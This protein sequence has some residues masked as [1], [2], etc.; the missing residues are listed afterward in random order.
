MHASTV[1]GLG[2]T[3]A[4]GEYGSNHGKR[5]AERYRCTRVGCEVR[6]PT[7]PVRLNRAE[8]LRRFHAF[9]VDGTGTQVRVGKGE[10]ASDVVGRN[11]LAA[12]SLHKH[13]RIWFRQNNLVVARIERGQRVTYER[14]LRLEKEKTVIREQLKKARAERQAKKEM[15][16][17][18]EEATAVAT[19]AAASAA[20]EAAGKDNSI[21]IGLERSPKEADVDQLKVDDPEQVGL[22]PADSADGLKGPGNKTASL[23]QPDEEITVAA[24]PEKA[25]QSSTEKVR[26]GDQTTRQPLPQFKH[27]RRRSVGALARPAVQSA[28][29][30]RRSSVQEMPLYWDLDGE[31]ADERKPLTYEPKLPS[32]HERYLKMFENH[33][34]L[35]SPNKQEGKLPHVSRQQQQL[36]T[37]PRNEAFS[38][39]NEDS[40]AK[41]PNSN[42]DLLRFLE[43]K[44]PKTAVPVRATTTRGIAQNAQTDSKVRALSPQH[45]VSSKDRRKQIL[46]GETV[47]HYRQDYDGN[48]VPEHF[49]YRR[50]EFTLPKEKDEG[51]YRRLIEVEKRTLHTRRRAQEDL[52]DLVGQLQ[53]V[54]G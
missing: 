16:A 50:K 44:K 46:D 15:K 53:K 34:K 32:M 5:S 48:I 39:G 30:T 36:S 22:T 45:H 49:P 21:S 11:K 4:G 52:T 26:P 12:Q 6:E 7:I 1:A 18:A 35:R 14:L 33:P 8:S 28:P 54:G 40:T 10:F 20:A 2:R 47:I 31:A 17:K 23:T 13:T 3:M 9:S 38:T 25:A 29:T 37:V 41:G 43:D 27:S 19:A 51:F 42:L 24:V